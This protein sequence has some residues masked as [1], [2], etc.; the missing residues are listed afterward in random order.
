MVWSLLAGLLG[1]K[2]V[3][4]LLF[5]ASMCCADLMPNVLDTL[6]F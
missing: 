3:F 4:P 2:T 1:E 5:L 6:Y